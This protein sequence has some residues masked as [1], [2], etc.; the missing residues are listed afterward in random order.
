MQTISKYIVVSVIFCVIF[1]GLS[2]DEEPKNNVIISA[3]SKNFGVVANG[4][5]N[6]FTFTITN[7][8]DQSI[9]MTNTSLAG[10][11][12]AQFAITAGGAPPNVQINGSGGTHDI[13]VRFTPTGGKA[14]AILNINLSVNF[15]IPLE[16]EGLPTSDFDVNPTAIDYGHIFPGDQKDSTITITNNGIQ[17]LT[18]SDITIVGAGFSIASGWSGTPIVLSTFQS[19]NVVVRFAPALEQPYAATLSITHDDGSK[20]S[21]FDISLDGEGRAA[22]TYTV[23]TIARGKFPR[24]TGSEIILWRGSAGNYNDD[25]THLKYDLYLVV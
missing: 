15:I 12:P 13:T 6:F 5:D 9:L 19:S 16:G 11:N 14:E 17:D 20:V 21:P 4:T 10:A 22:A 3:L 1:A 2:C 18:I 23:E 8:T 24:A 25:R 7:R